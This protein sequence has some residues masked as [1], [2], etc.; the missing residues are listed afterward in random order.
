MLTLG[1]SLLPRAICRHFLGRGPV[2]DFL[3]PAKAHVCRL[4][5]HPWADRLAQA[6][7]SLLPPVPGLPSALSC[8]VPLRKPLGLSDSQFLIRPR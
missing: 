4:P 8:A 7:S 6:R 2:P 5:D 3:T 1:L